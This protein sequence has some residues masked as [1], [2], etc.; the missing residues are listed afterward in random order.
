MRN[1]IVAASLA[2]N[3]GIVGLG[4]KLVWNR[5]GLDYI[6]RR[7]GMAPIRTD[8]GYSTRIALQQD[9]P[10]VR[11]EIAFVGDSLTDAM[12]WA[13][14]FVGLPVRN[15]GIGSDTSS[16]VLNRIDTIAERRPAEVFL[17]VGVNDLGGH[18][19]PSVVQENVRK[20]VEALR[21]ERSD[22]RVVLFS[23]LPTT[24]PMTAESIPATNTALEA[25]AA[26]IDL[27]YVDLYPAYTD[28]TGAIRPDFTT[29]GIHL[30]SAG[31]RPWIDAVEE[32]I[33]RD[34][35]DRNVAE[36]EPPFLGGAASLL[37]GLP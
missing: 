16:D 35:H 6:Q 22:T 3:V 31:Y 18:F 13:E 14:H 37:V 20:I 19:A 25:L 28:A 29:D 33:G 9:L 27:E 15:F 5:G 17:M 24:N 2:A 32:L 30:T 34:H 36:V 26:E 4:A 11:D 10:L 8:N 7:L 12:H 1:V 21:E 23:I